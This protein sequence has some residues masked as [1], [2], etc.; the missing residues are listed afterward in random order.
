MPL[1]SRTE[2]EVE[3]WIDVLQFCDLM[4][5]YLCCGSGQSVEFPQ[6][7]GPKGETIQLQMQDGVYVLSP[8]PFAREV[9]F[10]L[11]AQS[12]PV[13][14]REFSVHLSWRVR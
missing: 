11:E 6:P 9:E 4:S 3:Y 13:D 1:Q 7:I 2:R 5:L 10:S 8:S 14:G 12:Y